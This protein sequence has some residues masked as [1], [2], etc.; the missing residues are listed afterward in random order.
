MADPLT[1]LRLVVI[2]RLSA[3]NAP[4]VRLEVEEE[5]AG[6]SPGP[7]L[8]GTRVKHLYER[9]P[10]D[11]RAL[12]TV[13]QLTA[14]GPP[15]EI[16]PHLLTQPET[17]RALRGAGRLFIERGR[18][19][20]LRRLQAADLDT[21][22][23]IP[24][25]AA[26]KMGRI[27][28]GELYLSG[29]RSVTVQVA[30]RYDAVVNP[31]PPE[32]TSLPLPTSNQDFV[33]RD[34]EQESELLAD[35]GG[36]VKR[37]ETSFVLTPDQI[38]FLDG[39]DESR[40]SIFTSSRQRVHRL[41]GRGVSS[42]I[43]WFDSSDASHAADPALLAVIL[44]SYLRG[45]SLARYAGGAVL[46]SESW[47]LDNSNRLLR[48]LT[49]R[50]GE[51]RELAALDELPPAT[52]QDRTSLIKELRESPFRGHLRDYQID[53]VIW[54]R[55][56]RQ[57]RLGGILA[58]EMGLGKTVQ[59][60]AYLSLV[61]ERKGPFLIIAPASVV[62]NWREEIAKFM[63]PLADRVV[64]DARRICNDTHIVVLSYQMTR[65]SLS[66]LKEK[67]FDTVILDEAQMV[68]NEQTKTATAVRSLSA[69]HRLILTGTPLENTVEEIWTH[70]TYLNPDLKGV[71]RALTNALPDFAKSMRAAHVS[72]AFLRPIILRRVKEEVAAELPPRITESVFCILSAEERACYD[73]IREMFIQAVEGGM[74]ARVPSIALEALQRLRQVCSYPPML[75][76][77]LGVSAACPRT[78]LDTAFGLIESAIQDGRKTLFFTQFTAVLDEVQRRLRKAKID[79]VRLDGQT[80]DR[81]APVAR[82]QNDPGVKVFLIAFRA[83]G[84]GLNLTA[85]DRVILYDPWWNPAAEEQAFARAHRIGQTQTVV[86]HRV[87]CLDTV[88]EKMTQ[89]RDRKAELANTVM[90]SPER[91][92]LQQ[93]RQLVGI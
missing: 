92:S 10:G 82:F 42:G 89:L 14:T 41:T 22:L 2:I 8:G 52:T 32:E 15:F 26:N 67:G 21:Y 69:E 18:F 75:P 13:V 56:L 48:L 68:K 90:E 55:R 38:V 3:R 61:G 25:G 86:V 35:L 87:I 16:R 31:V 9:L 6:K 29:G 73:R 65:L 44:D 81:H 12:L 83:G 19:G 60:L 93:L 33:E 79:F 23:P 24:A 27:Q 76:P 88:E 20:S 40:W 51:C 54:M 78:K 28:H 36:R 5:S 39:L 66:H 91:L 1:P 64:L 53:G 46:V 80:P 34:I 77:S 59:A 11:E 7:F 37:G 84:F 30:F 70:A 43:K 57:M 71:Y 72:G 47:L 50:E 45:R 58:D 4:A 85:A 62:P 74:S 63:P 49:G 17:V